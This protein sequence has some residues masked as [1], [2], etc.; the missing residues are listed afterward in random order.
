MIKRITFAFLLMFALTAPKSKN[1][2]KKT[3]KM[4]RCLK[5]LNDSK[6]IFIFQNLK[7]NK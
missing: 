2:A 3:A 5:A 7:F 1:I 6:N 4:E